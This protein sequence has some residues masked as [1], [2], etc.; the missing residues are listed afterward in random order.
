MWSCGIWYRQEGQKIYGECS[1]LFFSS[2]F[3]GG[4]KGGGGFHCALDKVGNSD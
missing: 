1:S 3:L 2:F 4:G